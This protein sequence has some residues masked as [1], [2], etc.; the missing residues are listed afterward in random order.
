MGLSSVFIV[1]LSGSVTFPS[2]VICV[3]AAVGLSTFTS[4]YVKLIL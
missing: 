1:P 2:A 4:G 3:S